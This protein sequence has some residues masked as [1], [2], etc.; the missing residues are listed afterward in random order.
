MTNDLFHER[1]QKARVFILFVLWKCSIELFLCS[2]TVQQ[3]FFFVVVAVAV[4]V[5]SHLELRGSPCWSFLFCFGVGFFFGGGGGGGL[6]VLFVVFSVLRVLPFS[7][8]AGSP[9]SVSSGLLLLVCL[10]CFF[11]LQTLYLAGVFLGY[12]LG[13]LVKGLCRLCEFLGLKYG[14]LLRDSC[15]LDVTTCKV[16]KQSHTYAT[17][18]STRDP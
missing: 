14:T 5:A 7:H 4:A 8:R 18:S 17:F 1:I 13:L 9:P 2:L 12:G 10:P 3:I 15:R 16:A 11:V 6:F